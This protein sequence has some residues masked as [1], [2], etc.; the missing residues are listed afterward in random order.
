MMLDPS[1]TFSMSKR[2][3]IDGSAELERWL[4]SICRQVE[5][6]VRQLIPSSKLEGLVL[7]GGYGRGEGGVLKTEAGDEPYNDLE[8]Y[9]FLRGNRLLNERRFS[10][11]LNE[12]A[13]R[14]S[15]NAG[16]H[17]EFK[18]ESIRRLRLSPVSMFSYDLV[19]SH[20][21]IFGHPEIF[22][23][24]EHHLEAANI[25]LS[26]VTRLLFN[27]CTGLLLVREK[28]ARPQQFA[29]EADFIGRNLAK[30][31]L[32]LGDAVLA[33]FRKYHWSC[34]ER[35]RRLME[36]SL[37]EAPP[38]LDRIKE[39]HN[40]GVAFKLQPRRSSG[41]EGELEQ[42]HRDLSALASQLWLW[43]ESIRLQ[44]T[45]LSARDYCLYG[46]N[47]CPDTSAWRNCLLNLRSFGLKTVSDALKWRYPRER[48]FN[49]LPLLLWDGDASNEPSIRRL[50][51]TQLHT[52]ASD[53]AGWVAAYKNLW[54]SYG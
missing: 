10:R 25:P 29:E 48:L 32:A 52:A 54:P 3:T 45:F 35:H 38:N 20:R 22:R 30:A 31:Q 4:D 17:V 8:F 24:C 37:P 16:I 36:L 46:R 18:C 53:W 47:K 33:A 44:E 28:L 7:G 26:E 40:A 21:I 9:V 27:R 42:L 39:H 19:A 11:P 23:G 51:Q 14:L 12:L 34:Q 43:L 49:A 6:G 50:L 2:F 1:S 13:E 41:S 15:V 5:E